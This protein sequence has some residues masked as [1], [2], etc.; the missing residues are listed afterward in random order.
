[1]TLLDAAIA[2]RTRTKPAM[3][4]NNLINPS[5]ME[6]TPEGRLLVSEHTAGRLVDVT[7]GGDMVGA[8]PF[9]YNLS[10]PASILPESDRILVAETFGGR[11]VALPPIGGDALHSPA[12][13]DNLSG[14]YTISRDGSGRL[15]VS[16]NSATHSTRLTD[17]TAGGSHHLPVVTDI[18]VRLGNPGRSTYPGYASGDWVKL[19][20]AGCVKNWT[21]PYKG[22]ILSYAGDMGLIFKIPESSEGVHF[23]EWVSAHPETIVADGLGRGGGMIH[24]PFDDLLYAVQ[25]EAGLVI[26]IDPDDPERNIMTAQVVAYGLNQPTCVRFSADGEFMYVCSSADGVVW[27]YRDYSP[28]ATQ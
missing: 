27:R 7:D 13:A 20:T 5:H 10:A 4:A 3:W 1:M 9:A 2:S 17:V 14:P 21:A 8:S 12:F 23:L 28:V 24:N 6:W 26:A 22:R 11:I 25:P 15:I 18:P 19:A 16:E